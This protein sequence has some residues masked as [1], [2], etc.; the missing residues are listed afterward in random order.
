MSEALSEVAALV[1]RESGMVIRDAQLPALA[2][3]IGSCWRGP[4]APPN[5]SRS[6]SA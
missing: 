1:L 4:P 2:A 3:A 5:A 6:S